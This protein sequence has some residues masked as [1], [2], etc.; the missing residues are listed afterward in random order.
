MNKRKAFIPITALLGALLLALVATMTPFVAERHV[1]YAQSPSADATLSGLTITGQPGD[2]AAGMS[3]TF[4]GATTEYTARIPFTTSG[5]MVTPTATQSGN[6]SPADNSIIRVNG[7]IVTS[8]TGKEIS[9][10]NA[11]GQTTTITIQ[12]TAPLRSVTKTYKI[13][14]YRERATKSK[15]ANLATLG[16][17]G[18]SLIP[19]FSPGTT[20]YKARVTDDKVTVSYGLSDTGGG[21]SDGDLTAVAVGGGTASVVQSTKEVTLGSEASTTTITVPVTAEDS[22]VTQDYT[23]AVYHIRDNRSVDSTLD[24]LSLT[25]VG[26]SRVGSALSLDVD[27]TDGITTNYREVMNNA[28]TAVTVAAGATD[29]GAIVDITP[30][31]QDG[32][33]T[34]HQV[35]LSARSETAITV[36]VTAEDPVASRTYTVKVYRQGASPLS[37]NSALSSLSLSGVPLS[38][39]FVSTVTSYDAEVA[40]N[41]TKV[42]VNATP[43]DTT[44]GAGVAITAADNGTTLTVVDGVVTLAGKGVTSTITVLVTAE[45]GSS[46]TSYEIEVYRLRSLPSADASLSG[47]TL[48]PVVPGVVFATGTKEYSGT[49][50]NSVQS[51]NVTATPTD[52]TNG[53][54][55]K[56]LPGD[57]DTA[58][59][60]H[61]VRLTAGAVTTITM[62]VTAEDKKSKGIYTVKIYRQNSKLSKVNT[63]SALS[64]GDGVTLDPSFS[65][66]TT[67]YKARVEN[68]VK[69]VKVEATPTDNAG[70]ASVVIGTPATCGTGTIADS[71]VAAKDEVTLVE[72]AITNICVQVT[73]ESGTADR[74]AYKVEVYRVRPNASPSSALPTFRIRDALPSGLDYVAPVA[75]TGTTGGDYWDLPD[76]GRIDVA[77][78]VRKVTVETVADIGAIVTISPADDDTTMEGHQLDLTAGANTEITVTVKPEEPSAPA[79][80]YTSTV[81]R[82]NVVLKDDATLKSLT[83]STSTDEVVLTPEF[84]SATE[85]YKA[86]AAFSTDK[87]TIAAEANHVG[88]VDVAILPVPTKGQVTLSGA[89]TTTVIAVT[90]T[91]EDNSTT[92]EYTVE[93]MREA[94][95]S[96]DA[97]LSS[98][99]LS[100]GTLTPAFDADTMSYTATVESTVASVNVSAMA[101]VGAKVEGA[102]D[103][104]LGDEGSTTPVRVMVTAE[105][106]PAT[107]DTADDCM[108]E[109]PDA[110]INCYTVDITREQLTDDD[111]L[112]AIYANDEGKID[113][114]GAVQ[115][116]LD[117]QA[118]T[119]SR[120]DAVKVILLYQSGG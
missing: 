41:V 34:G 43:S 110:N 65:A 82:Q 100:A 57:A 44:G 39:A 12:V 60:A 18:G 92:K 58:T 99:S 85:D 71:D 91:A 22:S 64:L 116:V 38:P 27:A 20:S 105:T 112:R 59:A 88:Y 115:A 93:V 37:T 52:N 36:K 67:D 19:A 46:T 25:A 72:G 2:V 118:G 87:L 73:P 16:I 96:D 97:K 29:N 95:A 66:G 107:E 54:T 14:V 89:G 13:K 119:L 47:F 56:I 102:G 68:S 4:A 1:A 31:D 40:H 50:A 45:D 108:G 63:L 84:D 106:G 81:Y 15:D 35:L 62:T 79:K 75:P 98:L 3:P 33:T 78:R 76:G 9:L 104:A 94:T 103:I 120:A 55:V 6:T 7:S 83:L 30:Q 70:G 49:V 53:A 101:H 23:I 28:T 117:F 10:A 51:V 77:Y 17:T 114:A 113:R 86:T 26:G 5:A 109:T 80:T 11:A 8:G 24:T 42:T 74:E 69:K 111:R 21:A 48:D 90:V 61:E 32:G